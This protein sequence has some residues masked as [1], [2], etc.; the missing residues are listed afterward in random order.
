[1]G[2]AG[3]SLSEPRILAKAVLHHEARAFST[4]KPAVERARK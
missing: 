4:E 3:F 2:F 1:M